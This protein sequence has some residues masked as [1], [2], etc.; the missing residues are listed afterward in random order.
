MRKL[1]FF[2]LLFVALSYQVFAQQ[3]S[4]AI[5]GK[6]LNASQEGQIE[7]YKKD[8]KFFGKLIWL[9]EPDLNGKPKTDIKN[10]ESNLRDRP[11]LGLEI[12]KN[13]TYNDNKWTEGTIYDPKSGKKYNCILS[14]KEPSKLNVR[15]YIGISLIG[16]TEVFTKVK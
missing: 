10:P 9:K 12:L 13:F 1:P 3:P 16:R 5:V 14:L 4:D 7:I 2:M 15:G 6:W 8:G 11:L